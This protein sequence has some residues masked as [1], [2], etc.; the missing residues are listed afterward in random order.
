MIAHTRWTTQRKWRSELSV[1]NQCR[2]T[3]IYLERGKRYWVRALF[4]EGTPG[5]DYLGVAWQMPGQPPPENG[6]A[7]IPGLFLRPPS[8]MNSLR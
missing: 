2:S 4:K 5:E 7:P 8:R 1:D 6:D 3:P